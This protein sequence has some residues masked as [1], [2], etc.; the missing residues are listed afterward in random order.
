MTYSLS[1][2]ATKETDMMAIGLVNKNLKLIDW[3]VCDTIIT[4][5]GHDGL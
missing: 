2:L 1:T 4:V 5:K 3:R